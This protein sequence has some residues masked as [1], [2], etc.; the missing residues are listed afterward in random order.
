MAA[1]ACEFSNLDTDEEHYKFKD[2]LGFKALFHKEKNR[3][4]I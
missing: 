4:T 2:N 1:H 3:S